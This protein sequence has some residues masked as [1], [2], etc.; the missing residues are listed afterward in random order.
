LSLR[1]PGGNSPALL[2]PDGAWQHAPF[3]VSLTR[4]A[5]K[6]LLSES[7]H[8]R[9]SELAKIIRKYLSQQFL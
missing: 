9:T 3:F 4:S 6:F 2:E 5:G 8:F 1:N 7:N